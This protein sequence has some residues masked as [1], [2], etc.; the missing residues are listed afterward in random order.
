MIRTIVR[1]GLAILAVIAVVLGARAGLAFDTIAREALL[2]DFDT[3]A[4]M[5]ERDSDTRMPP[6]SMSKLMTSL[7]VFERLNAGTLKLTDTMHVSEK[8]WRMGGSKMFVEVDTD[9]TVEDLLRGIIVQSGNDACIVVAEALAGSED[10]FARMMT[11]RG[12]EIGLT[13][14]RFANATGWPHENHYMSAHDLATLTKV[15]IREHSEYFGYYAEQNFTYNEIRQGNRNPLLYKNVGAD[16]MKTG[17]TEAS[18]YGLTAT[19]MRDGRR[20]IL[21][22]NGLES[23]RKRSEE[24]ER[25]LNYG[26]REF[27]NYA[28]FTA[29]EV[30]DNAEVWLGDKTRIPL[31]IE[32]DLTV[33]L[34][35]ASRKDLKVAVVMEA[36]V[37]APIEAGAQ[38]A[39]LVVEAPDVDSVEVPLIAGEGADKLGMFRRIGAAIS[40]LVFGPPPPL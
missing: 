9:V 17:H 34:P 15:I 35:R 24:A 37:P 16:G 8:A 27:N 18:G 7:M 2:I 1:P 3:G 10:E 26:F 25:L 11:E 31:L 22:I 30:V 28:L 38:I 20:L 21:V 40:Y 29:G 4:V 19:A 13:G 39:K 23:A 14:S 33:T 5:L 36:P 32:Q 6:A 12:K